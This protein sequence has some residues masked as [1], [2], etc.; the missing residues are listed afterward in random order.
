MVRDQG[1][2]NF[3]AEPKLSGQMNSFQINIQAPSQAIHDAAPCGQKR[4]PGHSQ[5]CFSSKLPDALDGHLGHA[6]TLPVYSKLSPGSRPRLRNGHIASIEGALGGPDKDPLSDSAS[7]LHQPRRRGVEREAEVLQDNLSSLAPAPQD[8]SGNLQLDELART[9]TDDGSDN[10]V[11]GSKDPA[12]VVGQKDKNRKAAS[13]Q[14]PVPTHVLRRAV[15]D[16]SRSWQAIW[17]VTDG[18]HS[19]NSSNV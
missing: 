17:R 18:K 3:H 14:V 13:H 10:F 11:L 5:T 19:R 15:S 9:H 1:I 7:S 6:M 2:C 16:R 12:Q 8:R 4:L